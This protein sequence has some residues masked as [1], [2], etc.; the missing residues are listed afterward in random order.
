MLNTRRKQRILTKL[1]A[2]AKRLG[3]LE[4]SI[5]KNQTKLQ[6]T[7]RNQ[8]NKR[9]AL[10]VK[11]ERLQ[12]A[13]GT[14]ESS[15]MRRAVRYPGGEKKYLARVGA[16]G[17]ET[18]WVNRLAEQSTK[19]RPSSMERAK[20]LLKSVGRRGVRKAVTGGRG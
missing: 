17:A 14:A 3:R 16:G 19:N 6:E 15:V 12:A 2:S 1:A 8:Y 18:Y 4:T 11:I 10:K 20:N 13:A 9:Q 5:E 7:P